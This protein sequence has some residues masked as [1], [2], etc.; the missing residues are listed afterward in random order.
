MTGCNHHNWTSNTMYAVGECA[1]YPFELAEL[2]MAVVDIGMIWNGG[3][4]TGQ[5]E[6][7]WEPRWI[8]DLGAEVRRWKGNGGNTE[9]GPRGVS[10]AR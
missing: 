9:R 2:S 5:A 4:L 1:I 10:T 8:Y 3:V 6:Q 7:S